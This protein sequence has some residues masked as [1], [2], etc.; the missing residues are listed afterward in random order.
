MA[1][2]LPFSPQS[3]LQARLSRQYAA[4]LD[5]NLTFEMGFDPEREFVQIPQSLA[6]YAL[7]HVQVRLRGRD[8][9]ASF[10]ATDARFAR[11]FD[12]CNLG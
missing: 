4:I 5:Q 3:L 8:D 1:K 9:R 11:R 10:G 6:Q 2:M 7:E 12:L